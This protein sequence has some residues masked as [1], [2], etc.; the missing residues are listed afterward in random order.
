MKQRENIVKISWKYRENIVKIS[1]KYRE[2]VVKISW[3]CR[4]NNVKISWKYRENIMKISWIYRENILKV[5]WKYRDNIR[6]ST[7]DILGE[8]MEIGLSQKSQPLTWPPP[9]YSETSMV[10]IRWYISEAKWHWVSYTS[11]SIVR[12]SSGEKDLLKHLYG[13]QN[14]RLCNLD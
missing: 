13:N 4:D 6:H 9:T 5:S 3:K 8:N 12:S 10:Y 2:N 1:R 7:S 11:A 14:L